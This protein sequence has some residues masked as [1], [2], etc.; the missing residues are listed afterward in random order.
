MVWTRDCEPVKAKVQTSSKLPVR[1]GRLIQHGL[2][3]QFK[4]APK[5]KIYLKIFKKK[6]SPNYIC[7]RTR[8]KIDQ[9]S[10]KKYFIGQIKKGTH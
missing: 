9:R 3:L 6:I 8:Q 10:T 1:W 5:N 7:E 4:S 2:S